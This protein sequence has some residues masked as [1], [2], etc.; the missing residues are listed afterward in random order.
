[1]SGFH[2]QGVRRR[3]KNVWLRWRFEHKSKKAA[4]LR[5]AEFQALL[6]K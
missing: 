2:R 4:R 5:D 3:I 1:M 6:R